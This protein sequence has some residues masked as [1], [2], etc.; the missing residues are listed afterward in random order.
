VVL[1]WLSAVSDGPISLPNT[2]P[3]GADNQLNFQ[4][5]NH[6][7][8]PVQLYPLKGLHS[9]LQAALESLHLVT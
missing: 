6:Y 2:A 4:F 7:I 3:P 1:P 9:L 5:G 8:E